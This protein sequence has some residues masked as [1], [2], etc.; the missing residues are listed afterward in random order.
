MIVNGVEF[1][2]RISNKTHAANFEK[3]LQGMQKMEKEIRTLQP[4]TPASYVLGKMEQMFRNFFRQA[5]GIDVIGDCEDVAEMK[6]M[7]MEFLDKIA[8]QKK[9]FLSPFSMER[10]K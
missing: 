4:E 6:A 7:Y 8:E 1:D 2:F 3:A 9:D 10:I 5:T